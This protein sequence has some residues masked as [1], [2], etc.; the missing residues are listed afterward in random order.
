MVHIRETREKG[1]WCRS[2]FYSTLVHFHAM[3]N[4]LLVLACKCTIVSGSLQS[5]TCLK[6][7]PH[8]IVISFHALRL[9]ALASNKIIPTS[10]RMGNDTRILPIIIEDNPIR[11]WTA[12]VVDL[13]RAQDG[14]FLVR[15]WSIEREPFVVV[16]CVWVGI[17]SLG[18]TV[19][20]EGVAFADGGADV[21]LPVAGP[22]AGF[23]AGLTFFDG[24]GEVPAGWESQGQR[25]DGQQSTDEDLRVELVWCSRLL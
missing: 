4:C 15:P 22:A 17:A 13:E 7:I 10:P 24:I 20:V 12:T 16:V 1:F 6:L 14:E 5:G 18:L 23:D 25:W 2:Y 19:L 21:G 8:R 3:H 9:I 11:T